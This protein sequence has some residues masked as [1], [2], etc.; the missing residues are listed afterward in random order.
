[1]RFGL[2]G[3][4]AVCTDG[5]F[6]SVRWPM[7]RSVLATLLLN[8]NR[9]VRTERLI[10]VVWGED[11]PANAQASL[12]NH[13]MRLRALLAGAGSGQ[14]RT[15]APG[16][17]IDVAAGDLDLDEFTRRS[18]RGRA[19]L[20][21]EDWDAAA[22]ELA[23]ALDL[24]RGEPLADVTSPVLREQ[25]APRLAQLRLDALEARIEADLRLGRTTEII[26]ELSRLV[27]LHPLRERLHG[28]LMM[29]CYRAGRQAEALSAY[30]RAREVLTTELGIEPGPELR[31]LH[32][33]ILAGNLAPAASQRRSMVVRPAHLTADLA[34]FTGREDQ[35]KALTGLLGGAGQRPGVVP[36]GVVTGPGGVGKTS[37]AVHVAHLVRDSFPDGQLV[38][39]LGGAGANP[40]EPGQVLARFLRDLGAD[41]GSEPAGEAE[42]SAQ[43]RSM[44]A[45]RRVLI[46]LD[47]ARDSAQV[48]P[49]LPGTSGCAVIVTSRN[50][51][52]DVPGARQVPLAAFTSDQALVLLSRIIGG[53]R[54]RAGEQAAAAVAALCAGLPLALRIA[55]SRLAA[56]PHW[57]IEDLA[58]RLANAAERLDELATGDLSVRASFD[59][60]YGNLP[61]K[62]ALVPPA[63]AF[64]LLSLWAGPDTGVPAAAALFGS[65]VPAAEKA[66]EALLDSHLVEPGCWAGRYRFHDLL[67]V[68]AAE[69]ARAEESPAGTDAAIRRLLTWYLH[70]VVAADRAMVPGA[71]TVPLEACPE[72]LQP[73]VPAGS[74]EAVEWLKDELPNLHAAVRM[75]AA[76]GDHMSTWKLAAA[77]CVFHMR[78]SMWADWIGIETIGLASARSI[79][80]R[81]GEGWLLSGLAVAHMQTGKPG[82]ALDLLDE[83]LRVRRAIGDR[84]GVA[85]SLKNRGRL[86]HQLG[87]LPEAIAAFEE[88]LAINQ[89]DAQPHGVLA[90]ILIGLGQT[91]HALGDHDR[92]RACLQRALEVGRGIGNG[93]WEGAALQN[94]AAIASATG[95]HADAVR[96][97]DEALTIFRQLHDR[98]QETTA[99]ID[100]GHAFTRSSR[101]DEARRRWQRARAIAEDTGDPRVTVVDA[102]LASP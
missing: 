31:R 54:M 34:D 101:P 89:A 52:S 62:A 98:Y 83:S 92:A 36:V 23:A 95:R 64:R 43:F 8:A 38:V 70:S 97:Y 45:G 13:V 17:L 73:F 66:L 94:L 96:L 76:R 21:A 93:E 49:L 1:M 58:G 22:R 57:R 90:E 82:E 3:A 61:Q 18:Q 68:Y 55:G 46:L 56:R 77:L 10:D 47:D 19:A 9:V 79:G 29:A 33:Q 14:I 28:Q 81:Y 48:A 7:P 91:R 30:Q 12:H 85:Y 37:L 39:R 32:Q 84:T 88:A 11:P 2:L 71:L 35:V 26:D 87:R 63:Q 60:S 20:S 4:V 74:G 44:L 40:A 53:S 50:P 102:L 86:L 16:Y 41:S 59:V 72:S 69:R 78:Q 99:L 5:E 75:T 100:S 51:L 15:V 24:W 67:G 65:T 25:E 42:R 80:D 6:T 27:C